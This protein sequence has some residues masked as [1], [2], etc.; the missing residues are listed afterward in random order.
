LSCV[1]EPGPVSGFEAFALA[2][3]CRS[4]SSIIGSTFNCA[5]GKGGLPSLV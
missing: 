1:D 2:C 5:V 3:K 4:A